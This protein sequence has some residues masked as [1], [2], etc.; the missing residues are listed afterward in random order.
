M[1]NVLEDHIA[2]LEL[3][4]LVCTYALSKGLTLTGL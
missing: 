2:D 1:T 4:T 3:I